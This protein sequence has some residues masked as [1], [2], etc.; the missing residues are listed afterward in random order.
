[1][2]DAAARS[3]LPHLVVAAAVRD[4]AALF[5]AD[6]ATSPFAADLAGCRLGWPGPGWRVG[7]G[8]GGF[9]W[10]L[11]A[12]P[13]TPDAALQVGISG[14]GEITD[15]AGWQPDLW[16]IPCSNSVPS[17]Y[18]GFHPN[19]PALWVRADFD[20]ARLAPLRAFAESLTG[21]ETDVWDWIHNALVGR[22]GL[23]DLHWPGAGGV[24]LVL[25]P[26]GLTVPESADTAR[27]IAYAGVVRLANGR[28]V[29]LRLPTF[30]IGAWRYTLEF[31][32]PGDIAVSATSPGFG[33]A[34]TQTAGSVLVICEE[35]SEGLL[36]VDLSLKGRGAVLDGC[37]I[38]LPDRAGDAPISEE[39][40]LAIYDDP[41]AGYGERAE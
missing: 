3:L 33:L 34:I 20:D 7:R 18:A 27:Q 21:G 17:G 22:T 40:A 5:V 37:R 41:L 29:R 39:D 26:L 30:G 1:M 11:P 9:S 32:G 4:G 14:R 38:H 24:E 16:Y 19:V 31:S 25:D 10:S 28:P 2:S 36:W 35:A 6:P 13:L 23:R 12:T 15:L 8:P